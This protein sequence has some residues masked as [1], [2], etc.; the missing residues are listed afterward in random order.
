MRVRQLLADTL[1]QG[2]HTQSNDKGLS[3]LMH[4]QEPIDQTHSRSGQQCA[5]AGYRDGHTGIDHQN[6]NN[7][8]QTHDSTH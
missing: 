1:Q 7:T 8:G 6:R 5:E 2:S 4:Y 3:S